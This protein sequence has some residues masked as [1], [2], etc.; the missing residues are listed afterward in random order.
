[1]M[2][3]ILLKLLKKRPIETY[4]KAKKVNKGIKFYNYSFIELMKVFSK[5][6]YLVAPAAS[7]LSNID[8][9]KNYYKSLLKSDFAIFDSL[10]QHQGIQNHSKCTRVVQLI[11]YSNLNHQTSIDYGWKSAEPGAS[12]GINFS[13]AHPEL[14]Y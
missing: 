10:I 12:R 6:G 13:E 4:H 5:G 3:L 8:N 1:M 14:D 2:T 11:R 9:N 7:T